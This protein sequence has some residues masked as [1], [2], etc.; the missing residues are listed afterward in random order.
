MSTRPDRLELSL[1]RVLEIVSEPDPEVRNHQI[2]LA[3]WEMSVLLDEIIHH[4]R[5]DGDE[6]ANERNINWFTMATWAV[7]TVG[8][9]IRSRELPRRIDRLLPNAI[10]AQAEPWILSMRSSSGRRVAR[11]L[12]DGQRTVFLSTMV[13]GVAFVEHFAWDTIKQ[14]LDQEGQEPTEALVKRTSIASRS[15]PELEAIAAKLEVGDPLTDD[16]R[17]TIRQSRSSLR[18]MSLAADLEKLKQARQEAEAAPQEEPS[19]EDAAEGVRQQ[20][21][22]A[23]GHPPWLVRLEEKGMLHVVEDEEVLECLTAEEFDLLGLLKALDARQM[24]AGLRALGLPVTLRHAEQLL[25]ILRETF[26]FEGGSYVAELRAAFG[27]Y[28]RAM[29]SWA[30][31]GDADDAERARR[32]AVAEVLRGN[33]IITAVEQVLLDHAVTIVVEH[34]PREIEARTETNL[35][36][37]GEQVFRVPRSLGRLGVG[38]RLKGSNEL[39][40]ESWAR[41]LTD[42][43]LV[44]SLPTALVRVGRD[45]KLWRDDGYFFPPR[46]RD[47]PTEPPPEGVPLSRADELSTSDLFDLFDRS[48]GDGWGTGARDWRRFD[49]RMNFAVNLFRSRQ[50]DATLFWQPYNQEDRKRIL[51]GEVPLRTADPAEQNV[52]PTAW[53]LVEETEEAR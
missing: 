23:R 30:R 5:P 36:A 40:R 37:W 41:A 45:L 3:Y 48:R 53:D 25:S 43:V 16:D 7:T 32:T 8:R 31:A 20:A 14:L 26:D 12:E 6:A 33:V 18:V 29:H 52:V 17:Q 42:Q 35:A 10:R 19:S 4:C 9:N 49:E 50:Q 13:S 11:A 39:L 15:V 22:P 44:L 24:V 46:L 21:L 27:A 34:I 38:R 28:H 47:L 1:K 51:R 2:T